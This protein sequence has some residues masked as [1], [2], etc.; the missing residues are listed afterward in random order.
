MM[1][2]LIVLF[3]VLVLFP[4]FSF[5]NEEA[6]EVTSMVKCQW[7]T[8]GQELLNNDLQQDEV[9]ENADKFENGRRTKYKI[10]I[11]KPFKVS[12]PSVTNLDNA[13]HLLYCVTLSK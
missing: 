7:G 12:Q 2:K 9:F 5:A 3:S 4:T 13:Y 1:S 11:K 8:N 6:V 10:V